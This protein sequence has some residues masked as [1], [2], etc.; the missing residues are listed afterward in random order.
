MSKGEEADK[1][2]AEAPDQVR[3]ALALFEALRRLKVPAEHIYIQGCKVG[4]EE[5][6]CVVA[7]LPDLDPQAFTTGSFENTEEF[8][9]IMQATA[10]AWNNASPAGTREVYSNYVGRMGKVPLIMSRAGWNVKDGGLL[11][12]S[13]L[14]APG[15]EQPS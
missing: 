3:H 10:V 14:L 8:G 15:P 12:Q 11:A 9:E 2:L 7:K 5:H 4:E 1:I 13:V 6:L